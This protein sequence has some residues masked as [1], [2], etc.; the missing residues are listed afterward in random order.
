MYRRA[1]QPIHHVFDVSVDVSVTHM[2][3]GP[4][5]P[6]HH[7]LDVSI[8]RDTSNLMYR[9]PSAHT[10]HLSTSTDLDLIWRSP[11]MVVG[12]KENPRRWRLASPAAVWRH[13]ALN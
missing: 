4:G 9:Y 3:T 5:Y 8:Q 11:G 10:L 1:I 2:L 7:G 13:E 12:L 6:I